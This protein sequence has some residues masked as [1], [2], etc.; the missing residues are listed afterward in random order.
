VV[1]VPEASRH[2]SI[3]IKVIK[4]A[5]NIKLHF[6]FY[7]MGFIRSNKPIYGLALK[8]FDLLL[9]GKTYR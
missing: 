1:N 7:C 2:S 8:I 9:V 5:L 3:V 4:V 6:Y